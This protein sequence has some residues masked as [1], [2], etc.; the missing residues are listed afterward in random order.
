MKYFPIIK[1]SCSK[2]FTFNVILNKITLI[3]I[4]E[5]LINK[6]N[7]YIY[8]SRVIEKKFDKP[9]AL[10]ARSVTINCF[11]LEIVYNYCN[12]LRYFI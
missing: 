4:S 8:S 6:S 2:T 1:N 3:K 7:L 10:N 11:E 9:F 5:F 12:F